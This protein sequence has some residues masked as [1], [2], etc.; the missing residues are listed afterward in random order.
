MANQVFC[1]KVNIVVE[2]YNATLS[3]K[4]K[5]YKED[6]INI[7]FYITQ[8]NFETLE[9]PDGSLVLK[10]VVVPLAGVS[11]KMLIK[12]PNETL[13]S[14]ETTTVESDNGIVFR[15]S[16]PYV[17]YLGIA[18]M[19]IVLTD[20]EGNIIH[21][22]PIDVEIG[23]PI[24]LL[25]DEDVAHTQQINTNRFTKTVLRANL[26][27][28]YT[29]KYYYVDI[30]HNIQDTDG[31]VFVSVVN[32]ETSEDL[33]FSKKILSPTKIRIILPEAQDILVSIR[34]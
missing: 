15:F 24:G 13:I 3:Q 11:A 1:K 28:D 21:I 31:N 14:V 12:V 2:D 29:E 19:Q 26:T 30:K 16:V 27:Y 20:V 5:F 8:I 4:L 25:D 6:N 10:D 22:P 32:K 23:D 33:F 7:K 18:K 17:N 34:R 9:K